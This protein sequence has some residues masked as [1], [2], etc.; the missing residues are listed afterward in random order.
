MIMSFEEF[1]KSKGL[2]QQILTEFQAIVWDRGNFIGPKTKWVHQLVYE[3]KQNVI[4]SVTIRQVIERKAWRYGQL[5]ANAAVFV[6]IFDLTGTFYGLSIRVI[7]SEQI[8]HDSYFLPDMIKSNIVF[9]LNNCYNIVKQKDAVFI[10][11]GAYDAIA[12]SAAG[13]KNAICLLGTSFHQQQMFQ[14]KCFASKLVLCTDPDKAGI[15]AISKIIY[16]FEDWFD[17]Y[18]INI[19]SDPDEYL[20]QH[21]L[22]DLHK[23]ITK[24]DTK[25]WLADNPIK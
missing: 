20:T 5:G 24:I 15:L 13:Q 7:G 11:E 14:L 19:D 23:T 12:L 3:T 16:R 8:K 22:A 9:N 18:K 6:P 2:S 17:F 1:C 21:S 25:Q 10:C 4:K